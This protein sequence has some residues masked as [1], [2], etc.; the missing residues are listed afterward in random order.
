MLYLPDAATTFEVYISRLP[1]QARAYL[2]YQLDQGHGG[3]DKD[4]YEIAEPML[5]W[6][7]KLSS[8]FG[9][10]TSEIHDIEVGHNRDNPELQRFAINIPVHGGGKDMC[11]ALSG[12]H[13]PSLGLIAQLCL[14]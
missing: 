12:E 3:V 2:D 6:K 10:T 7:E 8:H 1:P 4:L 13:A 5:Y 9:L 11:T 14:Y